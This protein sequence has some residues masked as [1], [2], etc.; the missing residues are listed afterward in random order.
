MV[1]ITL[2]PAPW[3]RCEDDKSVRLA[4]GLGQAK[5]TW[6]VPHMCQMGPQ[7][8]WDPT[9]NKKNSQTCARLCHVLTM[10]PG[11]RLCVRLPG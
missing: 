8:L 1:I 10:C 4:E 11:P 7:G 5:H 2:I 6:K 3:A 9:A